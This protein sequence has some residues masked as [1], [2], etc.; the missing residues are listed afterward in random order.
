MSNENNTNTAPQGGELTIVALVSQTVKDQVNGSHGLIKDTV[1]ANRVKPEVAKRV[2]AITQ[3]LDQEAKLRSELNQLTRKP[4]HKFVP[5]GGGE[6]VAYHTEA[7]AKKIKEGQEKLAKITDALTK[8]WTE[9]NFEPAFKLVG[10][11][12]G[13]KPQGDK[14]A[15]ANADNQ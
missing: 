2:E 4:E 15:E 3:L 8:A 6:V 10:K 7:T 9:N 14:P 5:V 11:G 13:D 12:G 1:I